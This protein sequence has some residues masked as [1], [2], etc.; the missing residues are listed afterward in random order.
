MIINE[1]NEIIY[2]YSHLAE[3]TQKR[4][5]CLETLNYTLFEEGDMIMSLK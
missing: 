1:H 4:V 5:L 3:H 2:L